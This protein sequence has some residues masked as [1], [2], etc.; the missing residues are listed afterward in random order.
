[1]VNVV[2]TNVPGK[3]LQDL[4]QLVERTP[5]QRRCGVIPILAA[6]PINVFKLM[7]HVEH[8]NSDCSTHSNEIEM[9]EKVR[10]KPENKHE[11]GADAKNGEVHQMHRPPF[12]GTSVG[13]RK[14]LAQ[15]KQVE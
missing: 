3:P 10:E 1:M 15:N 13:R 6:V 9:N 4:W 5:L 8:P 11:T 2:E 14:A 7:L 12:T